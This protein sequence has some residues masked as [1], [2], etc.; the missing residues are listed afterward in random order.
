MQGIGRNRSGPPPSIKT[1]PVRD[2]G[3]TS[4]EVACFS[5]PY[6]G[7][8]CR[9]HN[10]LG[11]C[12]LYPKANTLWSTPVL[13]RTIHVDDALVDRKI[14]ASPARCIPVAPASVIFSCG[15]YRPQVFQGYR[16]Q[17]YLHFQVCIQLLSPSDATSMCISRPTVAPVY[18]SDD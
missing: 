16:Q 6:R 11:V 1:V 9:S 17:R 14:P 7:S 8:G 3:D 12:L 18:S 5:N 15:S 4:N 13:K 2:V 10:L